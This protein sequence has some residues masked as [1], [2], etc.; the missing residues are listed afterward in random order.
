MNQYAAIR[1]SSETAPIADF[2]SDTVTRPSADMRQAMAE[3][4]VGDDVYG[5]DPTVRA[6]EEKA[7]DLLG[8]PAGM[9]V[10]SGT[11]SNL[12]ALLAHCG[13]GEEYIGG[14]GYHIAKYEAG[15]AA[16]LGGISPRHLTP[17][18][19]GAL[20]PDDVRD[21]INP[22]DSHFAI[23][24]LVCMENTFNG[25][26]VDQAQIEEVATIAH[27]HELSVHLDGARLMNA[28]VASNRSA[29]EL[30]EHM[31]TVSL[32][33]SKGLGAPVGSVLCGPTDFIIRAKR[34]RK[35]LGGGLRQSGV[36]A[37]CGLYA[38]EN[39][40]RRLAD[41]HARAK[42]LA[43]RLS[44]LDGVEIDLA[45]VETNMIWLKIPA[46]RTV[47]LSAHM[48]ELGLVVSEPSGRDRVMRLVC[49]LDIDDSHV[50]SV[51]N[52]FADWLASS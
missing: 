15:G 5:D 50:D 46:E 21:A 9:F 33:L 25:Q 31:D 26:V 19:N 11:Q 13:R 1:S 6:L 12:A 7:A 40:V 8:K 10:A 14:V 37:A 41:D 29:A 28:V 20:N 48:R 17:Q 18:A 30:V 38:L 34:A 22:D 47:P 49:H 23:S 52:A 44:Q 39:N 3:A 2:R 35:M 51:A 16:V 36:L 43:E 27:D 45:S 42:Q 32:C 24:R 4:E